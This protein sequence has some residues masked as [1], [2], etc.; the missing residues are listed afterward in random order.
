VVVRDA[1]GDCPSG[2]LFETLFY[3]TDGGATA[4]QVDE[5]DALLDQR[6]R[7]VVCLFPPHPSR[8]FCA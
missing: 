6:F 2:C 8:D 7:E 4:V 3:F 1:S 5:A